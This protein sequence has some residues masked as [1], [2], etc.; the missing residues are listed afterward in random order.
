MNG[1]ILNLKIVRFNVRP[2]NMV[3]V[4]SLDINNAPAIQTDQV[5]VLVELGVKARRR[6]RVAGP[7]HEPEGSERREDTMHCHAGN[8]RKFTANRTI[9]LLSGRV[10]RA[11]QDCFKDSAP[12]GSNRQPGFAMR[13]EEALHSFFYFCPTHLSEMSICTG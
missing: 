4:C 6:A 1:V 8:L 9:K 5:M 11:V 10:I 12:L 2:A 7:G 3:K 13:S